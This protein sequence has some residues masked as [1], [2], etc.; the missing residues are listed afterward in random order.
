MGRPHNWTAL[1]MPNEVIQAIHRLDAACK[2]LKGII[3]T[4]KNGNIIYNNSPDENKEYN[5]PEI[6][7]VSTGVG[8]TGTMQYNNVIEITNNN[9]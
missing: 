4:N 7:G 2:K 9:T 6:T 3:F 5:S 1:P 8:N